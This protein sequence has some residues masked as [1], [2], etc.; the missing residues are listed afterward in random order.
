MATEIVKA[1]MKSKDSEGNVE[2]DEEGKE[3][4]IEAEVEYDFGDNLDA[5]VELCGADAVFSQY[6]A[7]SKV[8]LQVVIRGRMAA[9]QSQEAI[10][11][12]VNTWKPGMVM[13]RTQVDPLVAFEN[14]FKN[15]SPEKQA[16][17]LS[18]LGVGA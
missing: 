11:E 10:Q 3:I 2:R 16:E 17:L 7:N 6:R 18:K 13:E 5:A 4:Y 15:A 1:K 14:M 8:A 12:L 9:G